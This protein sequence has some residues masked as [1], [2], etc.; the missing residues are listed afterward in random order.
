MYFT[1]LNFQNNWMLVFMFYFFSNIFCKYF[2]LRMPNNRINTT[3][4]PM[5]DDA[6]II[7][8]INLSEE[9][10]NMSICNG[11]IMNIKKYDTIMIIIHMIK[12]SIKRSN[13]LI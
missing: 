5:A 10:W 2:V 3:T 9:L 8:V 1:S 12:I 6:L 13:N 11:P 7:E 4:S